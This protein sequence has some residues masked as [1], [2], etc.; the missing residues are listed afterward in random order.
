MKNNIY[1][2]VCSLLFTIVIVT[3]SHG[4]PNKTNTTSSTFPG[5]EWSQMNHR[6]QHEK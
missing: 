3:S 4:Q 6:Y 5:K 1:R 2:P